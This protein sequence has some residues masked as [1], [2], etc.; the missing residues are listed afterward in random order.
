M[1]FEEASQL[2]RFLAYRGVQSPV[3]LWLAERAEATAPDGHRRNIGLWVKM[4][5]AG[6]TIKVSTFEFNLTE[7]ETEVDPELEKAVDDAF[8][9]WDNI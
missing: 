7:P 9:G 8:A 6:R 1:S 5:R 4:L 2:M 3:V